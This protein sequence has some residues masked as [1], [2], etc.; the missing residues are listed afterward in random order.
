MREI[1]VTKLEPKDTLRQIR[2]WSEK[3]TKEFSKE[4]N[5][6]RQHYSGKENGRKN[7]YYHNILLGCRKNDIHIILKYG[8]KERIDI[9]RLEPKDAIIMIRKWAGKTQQEFANKIGIKQTSYSDIET[10]KNN[11]YYHY[12]LALCKEYG[13]DI[14]L[15]KQDKW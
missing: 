5:N 7:I 12:F 11:L 14:I 9:T 10:G 3:T 6:S 1:N 15:E 8:N 4:I 2:E 13:I